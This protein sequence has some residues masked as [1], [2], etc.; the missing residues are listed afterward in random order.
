M[1]LKG[2]GESLREEYDMGK[3]I[4]DLAAEYGYRHRSSSAIAISFWSH[5][6]Q[7]RSSFHL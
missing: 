1:Q 2:F 6:P 4:N 5:F 7:T 3:S